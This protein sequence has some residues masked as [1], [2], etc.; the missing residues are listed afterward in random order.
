MHDNCYGNAVLTGDKWIGSWVSRIIHSHAY[1]AG[2]TAIFITWDEGWE[3]NLDEHN[4][5][6]CV[7]RNTDNSCH[8]AT[9]VISPYTP[10]YTRSSVLFNHYSL[11]K[12][13]E[14]L[15]GVPYLGAAGAH[16]T[17]A[18]KDPFKL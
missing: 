8:I 12:T 11:L 1:Q 2:G 5:Q 13:S 18:L 17:I 4:H 9:I 10:H 3:P 16:S 6:S 15:L 14:M 7:G